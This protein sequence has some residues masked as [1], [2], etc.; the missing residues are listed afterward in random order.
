MQGALLE[1][2]NARRRERFYHTRQAITYNW[3]RVV[4]RRKCILD[5]VN[6]IQ[7]NIRHRSLVRVVGSY[8]SLKPVKR[9]KIQVKHQFGFVNKYLY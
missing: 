8:L 5:K 1:E 9:V 2:L 3:N 7:C 4:N 6:R